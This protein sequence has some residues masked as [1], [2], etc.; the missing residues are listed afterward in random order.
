MKTVLQR[1]MNEAYSVIVHIYVKHLLKTSQ[2][3]LQ[4]SWK[5]NVLQTVTEDAGLLHNFMSD[6]VRSEFRVII[7][8]LTGCTPVL[9]CC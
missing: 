3:K 2:R 6:L 5:A 9:N 4:K 1:V 8:K 7:Q